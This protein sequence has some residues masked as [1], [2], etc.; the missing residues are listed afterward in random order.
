MEDSFLVRRNLDSMGDPKA[1]SYLSYVS[2][3]FDEAGFA[4]SSKP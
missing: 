1:G 2:A 4:T 3:E